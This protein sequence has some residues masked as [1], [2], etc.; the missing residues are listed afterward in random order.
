MN[1]CYILLQMHLREALV[2][3]SPK[4]LISLLVENQLRVQGKYIRAENAVKISIMTTKHKYVGLCA[5]SGRIS[6]LR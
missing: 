2:K 1:V 6:L 5:D 4:N 3:A